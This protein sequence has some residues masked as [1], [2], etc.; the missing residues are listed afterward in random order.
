MPIQ[1]RPFSDENDLQVLKTFISSIMKQDMQRS[2]WHVGDLVWGIYQNTIYDPRKNVRLWENEPGELLGFAWINAKEVIIQI[3]PRINGSNEHDLL[4]Q[5]LSWVEEHQQSS[6]S[7]GN[8]LSFSAFEDDLPLKSLLLKHRYRREESHMLH[9]RK[10]LD[11]PIPSGILPG[12]WIIRH[13]AGE[14]EFAQRVALHR[15]VWHPSKVT[16]EAY[17]CMRTVPGYTPEL[18]L[19]AVSDDGTFASYCICWLDPVSKIGEFEPVGTRAAYRGKGLGKALMLA[20]LRRLKA[21]G[22]QTAIVYSVSS[23]E[24]ARK[25][26]ESVGFAVYNR[27]YDY[28][29]RV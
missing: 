20:G 16:L 21:T 22:M 26:Y 23:N 6:A 9:M 14:D 8:F 7:G 12:G 11:Q 13:V 15:E 29:K 3:A 5:M 24:A 1:S 10:D 18:D 17:R 27:S 4:E 2:Y 25:L 28:V 19:V